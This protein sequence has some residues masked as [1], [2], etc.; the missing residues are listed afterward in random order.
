MG[1]IDLALSLSFLSSLWL[2]PAPAPV[3]APAPTS[4][5]LTL[6]PDGAVQGELEVVNEAGFEWVFYPEQLNVPYVGDDVDRLWDHPAAPEG[7]LAQIEFRQGGAAVPRHA[8]RPG[9]V[10]IR[11]SFVTPRRYGALGR[12]ELGLWLTAPIPFAVYEGQS[13]PV[14]YHIQVR[15]LDDKQP[16]VFSTRHRGWPER[17]FVQ[18]ARHGFEQRGQ[19]IFAR[20]TPVRRFGKH[21]EL[22]PQPE[23]FSWLDGIAKSELVAAERSV[24]ELVVRYGAKPL[25]WLLLPMRRTLS[26]CTGGAVLVSREV[27][28]VTPLEDIQK[29][30]RLGL[31]RASLACAFE[32]SFGLRPEPADAL[33]VYALDRQ[34]RE[35]AGGSRDPKELLRYFRF[36]PDI[37][38]LLYAPQMPWSQ[39]Y[40]SAIDEAEFGPKTPGRFFHQRPF[41]KLFYEKLRD[42][43]AD[44]DLDRLFSDA[45][46]SQSS[47]LDLAHERYP[48]AA[49]VILEDF[50]GPYPKVDLGFS[51]ASDSV[52]VE[53]RGDRA[54]EPVTVEVEDSAGQVFR[55]IVDPTGDRVRFE[56][57]QLPI[58]EAT[59]DPDRRLVE[60][61][62]PDGAHPRWDNSSSHG[63]RLVLTRLIAGLGFSATEFSAGIDFAL[64][65][66]WDLKHRLGFGAQYDPSG[67]GG[68]LR[69]SYSFG[70]RITADSLAMSWS[71]GVSFER[72]TQG[73]AGAAKPYWMGSAS[74]SF[75]YDDRPA[76]RTAMRGQ[77]ALAYAGV[78]V[79]FDYEV[80]GYGGVGLMKFFQ[81]RY[82]QAL[83]VRARFDAVVGRA[84]T[85]ALYSL[86]G[87]SQARGYALSE[88]TSRNRLLLS[89]EYRHE[90]ARGFRA[91]FAELVWI[92]GVEGALFGDLA[93]AS[94]DVQ[95]LFSSDS[96][97]GDVGYG[98][99]ILYD[100]LG[101]NPGVLTLDF[102]IP[103]RR[104]RRDLPPV[105]VFVG[106]IQSFSDF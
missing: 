4:V 99:R 58:R 81:T 55:G 43:L 44:G 52:I 64:R 78:G 87:R 106:F 23:L 21:A 2:A 56:Q 48:E 98:I 33:A 96:V 25:P 67:A 30:H 80:F 15:V 102:G 73:F 24:N 3:C 92:D 71:T 8:L 94:N 49:A 57:A 83:A 65:R 36:V 11:F 42:R 45:L 82:D 50:F 39:T 16:K 104:V 70:P 88:L 100:Q 32:Q 85:Q 26:E 29:F 63:I 60:L 68:S 66:E 27:F 54:R 77:A 28:A 86:G 18:V 105:A 17:A 61:Q 38:S 62:L 1:P 91:N 40:F 84:P 46:A 72:L 22:A 59:L 51:I 103:L 93:L 95:R 89:M 10:E 97:Y 79:P 53:R 69:Y 37:D 5:R 75:I 6:H 20:R 41:G 34:H 31:A 14:D 101:V 74:S 90:I 47:V 12:D 7:A 9:P 13:V 19:R 35:M 76:L